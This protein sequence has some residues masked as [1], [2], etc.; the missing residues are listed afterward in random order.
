LYEGVFYLVK[1]GGIITSVNPETGA[2]LKQG[3]TNGALGEYFASPVAAGGRIYAV[4]CEGKLT[5]LKAGA[6]WEILATN[7]FG[8]EVFATPAI[9]DG[10]LLVRT[11]GHLYSFG[12]AS[13][14]R[15]P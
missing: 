15:N 10:R 3:R 6:Q 9:G 11:R 1:S 5:V 14:G 2:I 7:E 13:G 4:S 8:E 12:G